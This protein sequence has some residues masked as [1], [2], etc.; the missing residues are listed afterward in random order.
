[1]SDTNGN[2]DHYLRINEIKNYLYCARTAFYTLCMGLDRQTSLMQIGM[3]QEEATKQRM[4][5]RKHALHAIHDGAER[6]FSIPIYHDGLRIVGQLDEAVQVP[7]GLYL[8]DYKDQQQ[9]MGYWRVQMLA[10]RLCVQSMGQTVLGCYVYTLGDQ[11][12]HEIKPTKRDEKK[13]R[14]TITALWGLIEQD[15]CPPPT[16]KHAKCRSCRYLR[17]C[18]D[19][20]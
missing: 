13:L 9:D 5:R 19:I 1:M 6:H 10:Y 4:K 12:Y 15:V 3:E 14:D 11:T 16:T 20:F 8:V 7:D 2:R 17:F 18:N